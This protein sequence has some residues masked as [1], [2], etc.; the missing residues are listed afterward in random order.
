M[1]KKKKQAD[2]RADTRGGRFIGIPHCV[3]HSEAYTDLTN[4]ARAML[5]A[6]TA[7]MN[8]YNNGSIAMSV[9]EFET[10][11][12]CSPTN[13]GKATVELFSHGFID[14]S[15][16]GEWK[17]RK[18][19]QFR[20]T[21]VNTVKNNHFVGATNDYLNWEKPP[22]KLKSSASTA[23]AEELDSASATIA[24]VR[25]FDAAAEAR[26]RAS[27][28]KSAD[29]KNDAASTAVT[30]INSHT[31]AA[32]EEPSS[33]R[34]PKGQGA[35]DGVQP[36]MSTSREPLAEPTSIGAI[37]A[38]IESRFTFQGQGHSPEDHLKLDRAS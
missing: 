36:D 7:R 18:A 29:F 27:R 12:R 13:V 20:L 33:P 28:Q 3:F 32:V 23:K 22:E 1:A 4:L 25:S 10:A 37:L 15:A 19:R 17:A 24:P 21:F 11:L 26:I 30:L 5:V 16:E 35:N 9:R 14:I 2:C 6:L 8:G 31:H 38:S 34:P